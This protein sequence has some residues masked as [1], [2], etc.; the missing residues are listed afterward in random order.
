MRP[1]PR[2]SLAQSDIVA[3]AF[4]I[5]EQSGF[6]AVSIRGVAGA[7]G[8][9]PTA[10]YTYFP[11]KQDL[12]R[13]MVDELFAGVTADASGET[14]AARARLLGA[15]VELRERLRDHPGSVTLVTGH[16]VA[17]SGTM[18]LIERLGQG[19]A[20]AGLTVDDAARAAHALLAHTVGQVALEQ[21]WG[22][23]SADDSEAVLWSDEPARPVADAGE[24]LGL[25]AGD[26]VEFRTS[27]ERL[28]AAWAA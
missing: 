3:A 18:A 7:L 5:L 10:M 27:A 4:E 15:A 6:A 1:G 2:R 19:F 24:R 26:P 12:L 22:E 8:L 16:G 17:G 25:R 9:T 11:S 13:A 21:A 14:D 23:A 20:D 28:I